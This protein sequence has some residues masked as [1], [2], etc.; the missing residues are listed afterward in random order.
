MPIH[1]MACRPAAVD[2]PARPF[3]GEF[4]G[5]FCEQR[6]NRRTRQRENVPLVKTSLFERFRG[7]APTGWKA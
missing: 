7:N 2:R 6:H 1:G 3:L 4:I 5:V